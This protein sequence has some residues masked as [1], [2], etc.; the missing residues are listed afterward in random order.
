MALSFFDS[1]YTCLCLGEKCFSNATSVSFAQALARISF[2][3]TIGSMMIQPLMVRVSELLSTD[4][5]Q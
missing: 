2:F 1:V 3:L 5:K 4:A